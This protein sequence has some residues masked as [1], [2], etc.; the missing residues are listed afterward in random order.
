[1]PA[2]TGT[3]A[4]HL[5]GELAQLDERDRQKAEQVARAAARKAE[6]EARTKKDDRSPQVSL[7]SS[8]MDRS[9]RL[10]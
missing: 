7:G 9:W 5:R 2:V 10:L 3:M 4:R 8:R 1:M 6:K